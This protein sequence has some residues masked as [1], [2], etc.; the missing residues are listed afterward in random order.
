MPYIVV[1]LIF[2]IHQSQIDFLL[3]RRQSKDLSFVVQLV[4]MCAE[5]N[6]TYS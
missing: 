2:S 3:F 6:Y 5:H 1:I 4:N